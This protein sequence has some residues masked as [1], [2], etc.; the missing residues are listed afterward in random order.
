MR[1]ELSKQNNKTASLNSMLSDLSESRTE[2]KIA[3]FLSVYWQVK[4]FIHLIYISAT[5]HD[6]SSWLTAH[7][8][9]N[10]TSV[11]N[12]N[13]HRY[14]ELWSIMEQRSDKGSAFCSCN[15]T[16]SL[17]ILSAE[18]VP[19]ITIGI[20]YIQFILTKSNSS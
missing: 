11:W 13:G 8:S 20:L 6:N 4:T 16:S 3:D 10:F 1:E 19:F 7:L 9:L 17:L 15:N 18:N 2:G 14:P 5:T 12:H